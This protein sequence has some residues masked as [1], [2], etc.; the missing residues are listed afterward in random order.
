[1]TSSP[2]LPSLPSHFTHPPPVSPQ[3]A[4]Y[5]HAKQLEEGVEP[6]GGADMPPSPSQTY[7]A[8]LRGTNLV[9]GLTRLCLS[10]AQL[11]RGVAGGVAA[12]MFSRRAFR[13]YLVSSIS[14]K[15][16]VRVQPRPSSLFQKSENSHLQLSPLSFLRAKIVH[17]TIKMFH[18][19]VGWGAVLLQSVVV[20]LKFSRFIFFFRLRLGREVPSTKNSSISSIHSPSSS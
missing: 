8:L 15:G 9:L 11:H 13:E 17:C 6:V 14:G 1:M 10:C 20:L 5:T 7:S 4:L 16:E 18:I 3:W 2:A 12:W 19:W